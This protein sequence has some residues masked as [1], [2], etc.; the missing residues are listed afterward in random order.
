V[1]PDRVPVVVGGVIP[2]QD[3]R[4]LLD[5]G[6]ARVYTPRDHDLTSMMADIAGLLGR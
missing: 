1:D 3:A 5:Q 6:V 4:K 2:D